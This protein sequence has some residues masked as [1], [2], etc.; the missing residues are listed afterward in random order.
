MRVAQ[1]EIQ[2]VVVERHATHR[3]VDAETLF[4]DQI[5][6]LAIERLHDAAGVVE[7]DRSVVGERRGL[8]RAALVHR[9]DPLQLQI[10]RVVSRDLRQRAV[11]RRRLIV[12]QHRPVALARIAHHLVGDTREVLDLAFH[13]ETSR[14]RFLPRPRPAPPPHPARLRHVRRRL[15]GSGR[16]SRA[17]C[18]SSRRRSRATDPDVSGWRQRRRAR[19][20][21]IDLRT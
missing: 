19:G 16:R 1:R 3:D 4:P 20:N 21:A 5:A 7:E 17:S 15:R 11:A 9:P 2:L 10:L 12:P 18:R 13:G 6:G 8:I 14:R